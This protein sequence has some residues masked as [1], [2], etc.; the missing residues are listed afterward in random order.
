MIRRFSTGELAAMQGTQESA[1]QH[2][3]LFTPWEPT[4]DAESGQMVNGAD[5]AEPVV[6]GR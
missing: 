5:V 4:Q 6:C 1:M 3:A 2:Q